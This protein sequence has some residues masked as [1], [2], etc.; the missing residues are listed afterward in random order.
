MDWLRRVPRAP[1]REAAQPALAAVHRLVPVAVQRL[2][3]AWGVA[4]E[5]RPAAG[6]TQRGL[7]R[8]AP[9]PVRL[10]APQAA[11]PQAGQRASAHERFPARPQ[12]LPP[13]TRLPAAA[14]V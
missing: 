3:A 11:R 4:A 5:V 7:A 6:H 12:P 9:P 2:A 10:A 1:V 13:P 14:R 8:G